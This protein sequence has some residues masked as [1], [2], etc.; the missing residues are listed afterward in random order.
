MNSKLSLAADFL[1]EVGS[2]A[3]VPRSG[4]RHVGTSEQSVAE[5]VHRVIYVGYVLAH[6]DCEA[7]L[8]KVIEMCMLHDLT[9]S[10]IS[11]RDYINQKYVQRNEQK[12]LSDLLGD[13]PFKN[14][15]EEVVGEYQAKE[16]REAL[17]AKDADQLEL[18]LSLKE[19]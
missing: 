13:L 11:D 12:A 8:G 10:R 14:R 3:R 6:L 9:E 19:L 15:V 18:L 2:L 1:F 17:L 5:H 4:F 7:D 16:T